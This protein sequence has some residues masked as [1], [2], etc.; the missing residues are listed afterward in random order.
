MEGYVQLK[1]HEWWVKRYAKLENGTFSYKKRKSDKEPRVKFD[2]RKEGIKVK[3]SMR[4]ANTS[5]YI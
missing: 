1:R 2:I 5:N 4:M 3:Y